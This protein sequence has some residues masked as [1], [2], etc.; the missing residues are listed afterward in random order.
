MFLWGFCLFLVALG[1]SVGFW[2]S[3]VV[4]VGFRW[5]LLVLGGSVW[6][7]VVLGGS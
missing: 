5:F 2:G 4:L 3:L 7:L 6:F 1:D